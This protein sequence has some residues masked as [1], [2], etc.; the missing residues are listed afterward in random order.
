MT[1]EQEEW[2]LWYDYY[3]HLQISEI[4]DNENERD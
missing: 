1:K 3:S 4:N 2:W